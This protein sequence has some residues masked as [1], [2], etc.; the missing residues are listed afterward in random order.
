MLRNSSAAWG[1]VSKTFH[2]GIVL[3][4][5]AQVPLGFWL[6]RESPLARISGDDE[7]L[8]WL[9]QFHHSIGL[10]ILMVVI[11]RIWWRVSNAVPDHPAGVPAYQRALAALTHCVLYVLMVVFPFSGWAAS[12][13]IGSEQFPVPVNFFGMEMIPLD[14]LRALPP[15][16]NTFALYRDIHVYCWYVGG[17]LLSLHILAALYHHFVIKT[18]VLRRMWPL[19]KAS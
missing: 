2:W 6:S 8:L 13:I 19:A 4:A 17:A 1:A 3:L 18:D 10:L 9:E 7:L 15:P 16:F 14:F 5:L 11:G 12:S